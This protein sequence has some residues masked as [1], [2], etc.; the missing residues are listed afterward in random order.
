[1]TSTRS[2]G[3]AFHFSTSFTFGIGEIISS[4]SLSGR[5]TGPL[6][7]LK[8][9]LFFESPAMMATPERPPLNAASLSSSRYLAAGYE[10]G[11]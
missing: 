11:N 3:S 10:A 9:R 2:G 6:S 1:M 5:A 8:R 7:N 4:S